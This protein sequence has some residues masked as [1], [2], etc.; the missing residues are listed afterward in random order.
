MII[1]KP[2][3]FLV[4][5]YKV[6]HLF[7]IL[8]I[9]Y[10]IYKSFAVM[11]F[12]NSFVSNGYLT[13]EINIASIYYSFL[14]PL[15]AFIVV[16][17]SYM[18]N[19]LLKSKNKGHGIYIF[20]MVV[21]L[22]FFIFT[23]FLKGILNSF[24]TTD[25]DSSVALMY[26]GISSIFFYIQPVAIILLVLSAFGFNFRNF[27]FID[28]K[29]EISVDEADSEEVEINIGLEDYKIKRG[30]RKYFRELKYY[31]IEN[32][33]IFTAI[34]IITG[35]I[36]AIVITLWVISLNRIVRVDQSFTHSKFSISFND[37][38]LSNYDYNGNVIDSSK[39]YLAIKTTVKN[40]TKGLLTLDTDD[41]WLAIGNKYYYP[42]L[43]R[44][45]KFLDLAK[46]YY[47]EKIGA[48]ESNEYV[49]VYELDNDL[50]QVNYDIKVLDS[51]TYKE[52]EIIPKYKEI[53]ITPESSFNIVDNG[54]FE[55][56][57]T[58]NFNKTTLLNSSLSI[59]DY[60]ISKIY[61]YS[62]QYCYNDKCSDSM[63][64]V[65]ASANNTLLVLNGN[66]TLDKNSSYFKYK[67]SN[68][69]F[70]QDFM[71]LEYTIGDKTSYL[72][73]KD[74]TPNN[75]DSVIVLETSNYI[76]SADS[77]NLIITIRNQKYTYKLK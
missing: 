22:L 25:I 21:Y 18:I 9:L 42:V 62:Y 61:Q 43:D 13:K 37:A 71:K 10:L 48:G 47:G 66:I 75:S 28:I 44:S 53:T 76:K 77:I 67:L 6:I 3:A 8:P 68:N 39:I 38:L 20:T 2:Y 57:T 70:A 40:N 15:L 58:I 4:K 50:A 11:Q 73:V 29:D 27:E 64:S 46:P 51:I 14:M 49:L 74:V 52:K 35:I 65:T 12:F 36:L 34:G 24:E 7:M 30:F 5:H 1:R 41:F 33:V 59:G 63:N 69:N 23:L 26:Q 54:T 56:G 60:S 16:L 32:K 31:I 55:K 72:N 17:I 45:G 19:S